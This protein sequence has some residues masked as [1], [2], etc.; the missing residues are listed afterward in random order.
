M[1]P[2]SALFAPAVVLFLIAVSSQPTLTGAVMAPARQAGAEA[3]PDA[4]GKSVVAKVCTACHGIDYL[5][6]SERTAPVWKDLLDLMKSYGAEATDDEWRTIHDYI[7]VNL[8]Y[9]SVNKATADDV[10]AVFGVSV[11][12]AEEVVAYRDTQGGFTT[13]DDLKKAPNLDA[14]KVDALALRLVFESAQ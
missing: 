6:P 14:A 10:A 9:L 4:P 2:F 3:L 1:R 12:I 13:I 8:A 5:V 11:K 7:M